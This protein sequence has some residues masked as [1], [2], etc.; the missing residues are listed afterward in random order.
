MFPLVYNDF[1]L[2]DKTKLLQADKKVLSFVRN[3]RFEDSLPKKCL[4]ESVNNYASL[5][6]KEVVRF[7]DI[8]LPRLAD[9]FS[10]QRGAIFGFGPNAEADTKILLKVS[11][12]C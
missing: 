4:R 1:L 10:E 3:K 9:G 11:T 7:L 2:V 12:A 5:Y 6:S 8:L